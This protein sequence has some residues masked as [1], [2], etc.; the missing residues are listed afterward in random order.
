MVRGSLSAVSDR[1][2]LNTSAL[3]RAANADNAA[4]V[5]VEI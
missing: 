3:S 5:G 4:G 2:M 1:A